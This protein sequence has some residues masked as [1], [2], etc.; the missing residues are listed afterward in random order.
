MVYRTHSIKALSFRFWI[1][2]CCAYV[3]VTPSPLGSRCATKE[4]QQTRMVLSAGGIATFNIQHGYVEGLVRGYRSGILDDVDYH[5]L[6]Q[7]ES[8]EGNGCSRECGH[9][10]GA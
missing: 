7:C 2:A 10:D 4:K 9:D 6:T 3:A 5:H 1:Q 8:I